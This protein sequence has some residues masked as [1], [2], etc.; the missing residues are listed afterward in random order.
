[1]NVFAFFWYYTQLLLNSTQLTGT[2]GIFPS[3][4]IRWIVL[5]Y[6]QLPRFFQYQD[7]IQTLRQYF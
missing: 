1:M 6:G 7:K 4:K 5:E 2:T 3:V